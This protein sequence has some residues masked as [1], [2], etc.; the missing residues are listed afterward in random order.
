MRAFS[1]SLLALCLSACQSSL[2]DT[3]DYDSEAGSTRV[4]AQ[5][6]SEENDKMFNADGSFQSARLLDSSKSNYV[7][8]QAS[9]RNIN[10][11]VRGVSHQL[12]EN[13]KYV[14]AD[15]AIGVSSFVFLDG[16][17]TDAS[18]LGNQI[19]ESFIHEM[20]KF[21][22]PVIDFKLTDFFRVTEKGDFILSRDYMELAPSL[23]IKYVLTGTLVKHGA[24]HL[25]N[26]RIVG[27]E[28]KAVVATAQ[29]FIPDYITED[30]RPHGQRD[31]VSIQ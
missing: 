27:L 10:H 8:D 5:V 6:A 31:G 3:S 2:I 19:A 9:N 15:T 28:S 29:G 14:N 12:M 25:V 18:L 30:L 16:N 13:L 24:G 26:A 20:H 7:Y 21:G 17:Y 23:P 4:S 1:L 22:I 11:Y